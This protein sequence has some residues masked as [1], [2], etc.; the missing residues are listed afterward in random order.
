MAGDSQGV[1]YVVGTPL[2]NLEDLSDRARQTLARVDLVAAEDTRRTRGLLSSI[3]LS[4]PLI[5]YHEHNESHQT[6][7]LI[8]ELERGKLIALVS[9]AGTP[10]ISDPG[11]R[12]V[13]GCL[14]AGIRVECV[15]GPSA[16]VA[17]LS[18]CGIAA[19]RFTFEGFL[20]RRTAARREHLEALRREPR[21]MVFYEAVHRVKPMVTDLIA[22][23]GPDRQAALAREL[24]KL[25]ESLDVATLAEI[26]AR[27]G[28]SIPLKGEFVL[29]VAGAPEA[30]GSSDEVEAQRIFQLLHTELPATTAAKLTAK[31][32][33][34]SRNDV[35]RLTRMEKD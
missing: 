30:S 34:I 14:A 2:G 32:T 16:L 15:P 9:D 3:G 13:S 27:L 12:L 18:I 24:T 4:R 25:H 7:R 11:L 17:A 31:I 5:A 29:V 23:F 1:L 20:P 22:V 35:Y 6:Q 33:G 28:E 21:T 19:E 10:L 8:A 26:G